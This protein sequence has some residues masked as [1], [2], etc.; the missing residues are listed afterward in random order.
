MRNG[1][2]HVVAG[3]GTVWL[4]A[5]L[6]VPS[7]LFSSTRDEGPP[8]KQ[9]DLIEASVAYKK[10]D[11][12]KQPQKP[13]SQTPEVKPDA[14]SRDENAKPDK[15]QK[16]ADCGENHRCDLKS[17][18]C[19]AERDKQKDENPL[20]KYARKEEDAP[21]GKSEPDEGS[22]D[23]E[24]F[25]RGNIT[26]GDPYFQR[27][28]RDMDFTAPELARSG[29]TP[30]LACIKMT[31]EGKIANITFRHKGDDDI[32]TLAEAALRRLSQTRNANPEEV[33]IHLQQRLTTGE[34][35]CFS[36]S[37]N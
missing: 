14:V 16:D 28:W 35:I 19:V 5:A 18:S 15:C 8:I 2:M 3:I 9:Y 10:T 13:R 31:I 17:H 26:K 33:P 30:P 7:L 1:E 37:A 21:A 27:I 4:A 11:K 6:V 36:F 24:V 22:A 23:G 12:P 20:D 25:G 29:A 34:G 32:A